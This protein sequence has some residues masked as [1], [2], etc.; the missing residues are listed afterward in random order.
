MS[1][2]I[3]INTSMFLSAA[4]CVFANFG[5]VEISRFIYLVRSCFGVICC[6]LLRRSVN[7]ASTQ[8]HRKPRDSA[9]GRE[10]LAFVG[11][12]PALFPDIGV[13]DARVC[14]LC[15]RYAYHVGATACSFAFD[16]RRV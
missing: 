12:R 14:L 4:L 11:I 13:F 6:L 2:N 10:A 8:P 3:N 5:C 7:D 9:P 1:I 16:L 15:S